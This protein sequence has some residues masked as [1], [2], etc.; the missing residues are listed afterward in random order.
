MT[1][2]R[3][4]RLNARTSKV[5]VMSK[6]DETTPWTRFHRQIDAVADQNG[7]ETH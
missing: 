6:L 1:E 2:T 3:A 4:P 7:W 5:V